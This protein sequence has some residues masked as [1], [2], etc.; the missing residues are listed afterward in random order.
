MDIRNAFQTTQTRSLAMTA[1]LRHAIG[2][3]RLGNLALGEH[4]ASL[5]S[6]NPYIMIGQTRSTSALR[7]WLDLLMSKPGPGEPEGP[8]SSSLGS[9]AQ[10]SGD[11][12]DAIQNATAPQA[13]LL[14]HVFT[15]IGLLFRDPEDM[16]VAYAF[17]EALEPSGWL[18]CGHR[19]I[20]GLCGCTPEHAAAVLAR[21]Q[22][23]EPPG[24]FA[25]SLAECLRLQAVD[26]DI[27]TADF[28][29]LLDNLPVL[30][31]GDTEHLTKLCG[32][33]DDRLQQMIRQLRGLT[34]KPGAAFDDALPITEPDLIITRGRNGWLV[35]LNRSTLPTIE[36]RNPPG[37][38]ESDQL[39]RDARLLQRAVTRRNVTT[40]RI[41]EAVVAAQD[42]FLRHGA[43]RI[44][45]LS[46]ADVAE[47]IGVH[48]STVSRV[49]S[50]LL[51]AA[52]RGTVRFRDFFSAAFA[53][54]GPEPRVATGSIQHA[55]G[56]LIAAEDP[57][58]PLRDEDIAQHFHNL[59]IPLARRTVAKYRGQL[60]IPAS[61]KRKRTPHRA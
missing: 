32:C 38:S 53:S 26:L 18:S 59:G 23:I 28:A 10:S 56:A 11:S 54:S 60:R 12:A 8:M 30:A 2:L 47:R 22:Q 34:P 1:H 41:A 51:V 24:L 17:A 6:S 21:L 43:A 52:P 58:T 37:V 27:L 42:G 20:A 39:L 16:R 44:K 29:Q 57:L 5:A 3:L 35:D 4:I 9:A 45:P 40:L 48:R 50:G 49:T 13:G 33:D 46:F 25:R 14:Q 36:V 61:S 31:R 7:N 19:D 55:L 15:Q